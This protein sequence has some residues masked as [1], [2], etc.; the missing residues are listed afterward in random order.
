MAAAAAL[1]QEKPSLLP[2]GRAR[3]MKERKVFGGMDGDG[4]EDEEDEDEVDAVM[5]AAAVRAAPC[6]QQEVR[7]AA[8]CNLGV[9]RRSAGGR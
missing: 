5:G 4:G 8:L 2:K 9:K 1:R 6:S 7:W 3:L